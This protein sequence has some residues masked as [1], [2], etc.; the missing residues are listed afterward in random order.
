[1]LMVIPNSKV[2]KDYIYNH[3]MPYHYLDTLTGERLD[4]LS[5][6]LESPSRPLS[7]DEKIPIVKKDECE[8][9]GNCMDSNCAWRQKSSKEK[10]MAQYRYKSKFK[11]GDQVKVLSLP[12]G[13]EDEPWWKGTVGVVKLDNGWGGQPVVNGK[14]FD[15][16]QLELIEAASLF[17]EREVNS[18]IDAYPEA[19]SFSFPENAFSDVLKILGCA[20]GKNEW[21]SHYRG[22][23]LCCGGRTGQDIRMLRKLGSS[24]ARWTKG[25]PL[26]PSRL[27]DGD[28]ESLPRPL[29]WY[30][31]ELPDVK[32]SGEEV[33][34]VDGEV[35][36]RNGCDGVI[37]LRPPE[38][39]S[40]HLGHAPCGPCTEP[41]FFCNKCDWDER[42]D[43]EEL[44]DESKEEEMAKP[45]KV[46]SWMR[47]ESN[48]KIFETPLPEGD[49]KLEE[50]KGYRRGELKKISFNWR[51]PEKISVG[52]NDPKEIIVA[53]SDCHR[54]QFTEG[55]Q[56]IWWG[57]YWREML[58]QNVFILE[59]RKYSREIVSVEEKVVEHYEGLESLKVKCS[60]EGGGPRGNWN[61]AT[62]RISGFLQYTK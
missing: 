43:E 35:C 18:L 12:Y 31:R 6:L 34:C 39:C 10:K 25:D 27:K 50:V 32:A 54:H 23:R 46:T 33:G 29:D 41:R 51:K 52:Y 9:H 14:I 55:N 60:S 13:C 47:F 20:C 37:E 59:T 44:S 61:T 5:K 49:W 28:M 42:Y 38:N 48:G 8:M 57:D 24:Y 4:M 1:M 26:P 16:H 11:N 7:R 21:E 40:C 36:K 45:V 15:D 2:L 58:V 3:L 30:G 62:G 56:L 22:K 53:G 19:H 17:T